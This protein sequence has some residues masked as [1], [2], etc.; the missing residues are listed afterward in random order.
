DQ[1]TGNAQS[2]PKDNAILEIT[3]E[4]EPVVEGIINVRVNMPESKGPEI[5][6]VESLNASKEKISSSTDGINWEE[7]ISESDVPTR[8][9]GSSIP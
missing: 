6:A 8:S 4:V 1:E 5:P 9:G 2:P 3:P 7:M